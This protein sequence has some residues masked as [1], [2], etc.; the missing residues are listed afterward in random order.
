ILTNTILILI[1]IFYL[2]KI[3]RT[4]ENFDVLEFKEGDEIINKFL[5]FY[6]T[7]INA[8]FPK[9]DPNEKNNL[10]FVV[11]RD[12]VIANIFVADLTSDG[13]ANVKINYT[14]T[15]YRDYKVGRFLFEKEKKY[16]VSKGVKRIVY[17]E[18][19]NEQHKRFLKVMGFSSR[20][21]DN[22]GM[23]EKSLV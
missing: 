15:K 12:L 19:L 22:M 2:I 16:L 21:E 1:N 18:V 3:Y 23:Y 4:S 10:S 8:Y 7:D 14:V 6:K 5:K 13:T 11:L 9:F 20:Y 17:K